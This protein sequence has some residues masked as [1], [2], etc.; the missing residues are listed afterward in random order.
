MKQKKKE[1]LGSFP[2][3][4]IEYMNVLSAKKRSKNW[5]ESDVWFNSILVAFF[6]NQ[7]KFFYFPVK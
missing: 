5:I 4:L 7:V 1:N 2:D 6:S 3:E